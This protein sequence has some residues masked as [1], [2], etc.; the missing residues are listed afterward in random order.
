MLSTFQ[1][2]GRAAFV[3]ALGLMMSLPALSQARPGDGR[4]AASTAGERALPPAQPVIVSAT[5]QQQMAA[6]ATMRTQVRN[7]TLQAELR[8]LALAQGLLA[9]GDPARAWLTW[10]AVGASS[11]GLAMAGAPAAHSF[12]VPLLRCTRVDAALAQ[13]LPDALGNDGQSEGGITRG[14]LDAQR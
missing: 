7:Q 14:L 12:D 3:L 8:R 2:V 10:Q 5:R 6:A 13:C 9:A 1:P 11:L 4:P